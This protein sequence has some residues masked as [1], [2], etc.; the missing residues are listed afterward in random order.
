MNL[1]FL[2]S[3]NAKKVSGTTC[4]I[5]PA[6]CATTCAIAPIVVAGGLSAICPTIPFQGKIDTTVSCGGYL[7]FKDEADTINF[8]I[9]NGAASGATNFFPIFNGKVTSA[10]PALYFVGNSV[11]GP[12]AGTGIITFD[13]RINN[14]GTGS[15]TVVL[16]NFVSGYGNSKGKIMADGTLCTIQAVCSPNICAT[17]CVQ[18]PTIN[19]VG[20]GN[21]NL[22][23]NT[24][25]NDAGDIVFYSGGSL[26]C[27][28]A[29]LWSS[30]NG[31]L[32]YRNACSGLTNWT[33]YHDGNISQATVGNATNANSA[34]CF[35]GFTKE[36]FIYGCNGSG[37]N[38]ASAIYN[39]GETAMY[40]S[41]FWE[42]NGANWTP[43]TDWYWGLTAA[44]T[45]NS[46]TYNYSLQLIGKN[47]GCD[48]Y[49]RTIA[50]TTPNPWK[51][52]YVSGDTVG[53]GMNWAGTTANGLGT[54]VSS[55][56]I[57]SNPNLTFNGT[58][59]TITG[60]G[61][62]TTCL[63]SAY[64]YST[65]VVCAGTNIVATTGCALL[66]NRI[67]FVCAT[68]S[69][70]GWNTSSFPTYGLCIIGQPGSS[71]ANG[72]A[73]C[74][75][76][77]LGCGSTSGTLCGGT[78][79][80]RGGCGCNTYGAGGV[81]CG[82]NVEI[83]GGDAYIGMGGFVGGE[84]I[85]CGGGGSAGGGGGSGGGVHIYGGVGNTCGAVSLYNG[86][87][88]KF[89]TNPL[90]VCVCGCLTAT[91][92]STPAFRMTTSPAAGRILTSDSAGAG[93][94][95]DT[96]DISTN[97]VIGDFLYYNGSTISGATLNQTSTNVITM[98]NCCLMMCSNADKIIS[99]CNMTTSTFRNFYICSAYGACGIGGNMFLCA[100][101]GCRTGTGGNTC[102]GWMY[103]CGGNACNTIS[104]TYGVSCGGDVC[105]SA[106]CAGN[107]Y[108]TTTKGGDIWLSAGCATGA[109]TAAQGGNIWLQAGAGYSATY[110]G[111]IFLNGGTIINTA[112][113]T[114]AC[115]CFRVQGM[116]SSTYGICL[117]TGCG[118]AAQGWVTVSDCRRKTNIEPISNA[119]SIVTQLHGVY[120][121]Y[122]DDLVHRN[123][124]LIAQDVLPVLPEVV[125]CGVPDECEIE[126]G[127]TDTLYSLGYGNI[128][129]V[130]IEAIK[131]QQ[132]QICC[133]K[134]EICCLKNCC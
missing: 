92:I 128:T 91:C 101:R 58:T 16:A 76:G 125:G 7:L 15:S 44:H 110:C 20:G 89:C 29:R 42:V 30:T 127:I 116:G 111:S 72:G 46:P 34:T 129:A 134:N 37:S 17:T 88:L 54:Y 102:G 48:F 123:V 13:G 71:S 31:C 108:A 84:V 28:W 1:N 36:R 59:L 61:C 70:I 83:L 130:L 62:A 6:I 119:L 100:G 80:I 50:N 41:G 113:I 103:I 93:T 47:N 53:G 12:S 95:C 2:S 77:G 51:R 19:I 87:S 90:G 55:T 45:S 79:V 109:Y 39:S 66:G 96:T 40:K 10:N 97:L 117:A 99:L 32:Y 74:V 115:C 9:S 73:V 114:C 27:E 85:I 5:S 120:F 18:A 35:D 25:S 131:E 63:R 56:C 26:S 22:L 11:S 23:A 8:S 105:I 65:G 24:G 14:A 75:I 3:I 38:I 4:V 132:N 121:N 43:T 67:A 133:L 57:C 64:V 118:A 81:G 60:I 112:C 126:K 94:W 52:I 98:K 107:A 21:L 104:G 106:G 68:D 124:G 49:L 78:A 82:G 69:C 122:C 33:V 86:P